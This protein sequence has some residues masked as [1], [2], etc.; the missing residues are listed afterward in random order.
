MIR[1]TIIAHGG[2]AGFH[3]ELY[4]KAR[5]KVMAERNCGKTFMANPAGDA[6]VHIAVTVIEKQA[7]KVCC[8]QFL[9]AL[10]LKMADDGR[11]KILKAKLK[12]NFLFGNDNAPL[13]IIEAKQ[14][15]LDYTMPV[16]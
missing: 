8:D 1:N 15:L 3:K 16:N 5:E 7:R 10:F 14:V 6:N 12:N 13:V 11:Y 4:T 2:K 9:A